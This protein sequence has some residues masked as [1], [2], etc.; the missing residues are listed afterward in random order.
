MGKTII[1]DQQVLEEGVFIDSADIDDSE[2]FESR[3]Y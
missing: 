1:R 2:I 3:S